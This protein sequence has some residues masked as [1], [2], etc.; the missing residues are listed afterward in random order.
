[1]AT[2]LTKLVDTCRFRQ[3]DQQLTDNE[4]TSF[5]VA[6]SKRIDRETICNL[7]SGQSSTSKDNYFCIQQFNQIINHIILKRSRNNQNEMNIINQN[8]M[9]DDLPS[10][11]I[12]E[13]GSYL[14]QNDYPKFARC[15]QSLFISLNSPCTLQS[16][17]IKQHKNYRY[18]NCTQI[19][20]EN[21]PQIR[22]L[23]VPLSKFGLF[24]LPNH[25]ICNRLENIDIYCC[26]GYNNYY[27]SNF[28]HQNAI[29]LSKLKQASIFYSRYK[30]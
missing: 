5:L 14:N 22:S 18:I 13:I 24:T 20:L 9:I 15:N 27:M 8:Q 30:N 26:N 16:I 7:L 28:L 29:N 19:A 2:S 11:I 25:T 21:Y 12:G 6:I 1:M 23:S 17:E 10:Q 3:S 4:Y